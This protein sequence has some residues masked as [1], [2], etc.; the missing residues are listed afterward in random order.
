MELLLERAEEWGIVGGPA[1]G[2]EL[3]LVRRRLWSQIVRNLSGESAY[4]ESLLE[5]DTTCQRAVE[6]LK[7][8]S[9][10]VVVDGKVVLAHQQSTKNQS[11]NI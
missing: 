6:L 7:N 10:W 1:P 3:D 8:T 2:A 4:Y 9:A 5:G 11:V